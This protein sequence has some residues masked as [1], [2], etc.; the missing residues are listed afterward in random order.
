[1]GSQNKLQPYKYTMKTVAAGSS[2]GICRNRFMMY[3]IPPKEALTIERLYCHFVMTFDASVAAADRRIES[4][5]IIDELRPF[6][7]TAVS[8][9]QRRQTVNL[10]A[11]ANRRVDL[12][13]DLTHLLDH[14]NVAYEESVYDPASVDTGFTAVEIMLPNNLVETS[15]VGA[16][17]LWKID[18][19]FTTTGIR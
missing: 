4:I 14:D 18:G 19:L 17:V 13:I 8:N 2:A 11:D 12:S 10:S 16:L 5:G 6:P 3:M 7:I 1:M 9:Y 15:T